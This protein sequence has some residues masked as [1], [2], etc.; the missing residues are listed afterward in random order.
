MPLRN[1]ARDALKGLAYLH[2]KGILHLDVKPA[3]M[4]VTHQ[5]TVKLGDFGTTMFLNKTAGTV[6][7]GQT[8]GTPAYMAPEIISSGKF[9]RGSDIWAWAC[10]VVEMASGETPWSHLP[11]EKHSALPL[12]FHIATAKPPA[13]CPIIPD[14]LSSSLKEILA[15]CF[16]PSLSLRPNAE[17]LLETEYFSRDSLPLDV[18]PLERY[19]EQAQEVSESSVG[20][21][22]DGSSW[23]AVGSGAGSDHKN[24]TTTL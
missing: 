20:G 17:A 3:N 10:S 8:T 16:S 22:A 15:A 12:M 19:Y 1:Y 18:E 11:T 7:T 4:L 24:D 6:M 23:V 9:Y 21:S 5:G 13:H 2:G 14:H